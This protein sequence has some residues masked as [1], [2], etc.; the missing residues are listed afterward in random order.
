MASLVNM[1]GHG[2]EGASLET[3]HPSSG[4]PVLMKAWLLAQ[5]PNGSA[6]KQKQLTFKLALVSRERC[7]P[8][9]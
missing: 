5:F 2:G 9:C 3:L 7:L 6:M 4:D 1:L 8:G